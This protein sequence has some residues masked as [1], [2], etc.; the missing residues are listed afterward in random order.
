M[1]RNAAVAVE[2]VF[3]PTAMQIHLHGREKY[4]AGV[5]GELIKYVQTL[6]K[7]SVPVI[8]IKKSDPEY[9]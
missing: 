3:Q 8:F 1:I 9:F 6:S 5:Q 4:S 2:Q 7:F